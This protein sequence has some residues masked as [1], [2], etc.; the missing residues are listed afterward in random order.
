MRMSDWSSDVCSA[1]LASGCALVAPDNAVSCVPSRETVLLRSIIAYPLTLTGEK[2]CERTAA[3]RRQAR[4]C[5]LADRRLRRL[6]ASRRKAERRVGQECVG[7][8]RSRWAPYTY[9][10]NRRTST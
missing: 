4:R 3:D 9:K 6:E 2:S 7:K 8:C 1:D 10:K 5:E